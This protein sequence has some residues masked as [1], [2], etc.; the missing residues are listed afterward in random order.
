MWSFLLAAG[1][2][3]S[4]RPAVLRRTWHKI[5]LVSMALVAGALVF[6]VRDPA[7]RVVGLAIAPLV[8][9]TN[10]ALAKRAH[11]DG[12]AEPAEAS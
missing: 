10:W 11:Q 8:F 2:V 9:V 1:I 4:R 7:W 3:R 12:Q 5:L 6:L